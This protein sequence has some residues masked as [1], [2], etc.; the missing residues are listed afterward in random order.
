MVGFGS[1]ALMAAGAAALIL[2]ELV[3]IHHGGSCSNGAVSVPVRRCTPT[4]YRAGGLMAGGIVAMVFGGIAIAFTL[5]AWVMF[6]AMGAAFLTGSI[7]VLAGGTT[8]LSLVIVWGFIGVLFL[9]LGGFGLRSEVRSVR[10]GRADPF[11][12]AG[13]SNDPFA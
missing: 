12:A 4:T 7:S 11:A 5:G 3:L 1:L 8:I 13:F 2:G 10:R 9:F 6:L